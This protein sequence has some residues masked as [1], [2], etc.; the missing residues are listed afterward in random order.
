MSW[1]RR[2][3]LIAFL[4][5]V[6]GAGAWLWFA[7][8]AHVPTAIAADAFANW[9]IVASDGTD[10]WVVAVTPPARLVATLAQDA[11]QHAG[12]PLLSPPHAGMPLV[13][14]NEFEEGLQGVFGTDSVMRM[15]HDAGLDASRL[16]PVCLA[17]QTRTDANGR[18]EVY[19][20]PFDSA[21]FS[22]LRVDL[23]PA[24]PEQAGTGIYDPS[25]LSPILIVGA[26]D[27]AFERWWPLR[28]DHE[29]DCVA[30]V[31]VAAAAQN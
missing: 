13:L 25:T 4:V 30:D 9:P 19:F 22:Q 18:A 8:H 1:Q 20:V 15:A 2:V 16:E 27:D 10:P 26:T 31:A 3:I 17:H 29:R 5:L 7:R 21:P 28:F 24:F 11:T 23:I 12:R 14:R 6:G